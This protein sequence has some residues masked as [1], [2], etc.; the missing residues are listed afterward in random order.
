MH[1]RFFA[2]GLVLALSIA[3]AAL[4]HQSTSKIAAQ[5]ETVDAG[6]GGDSTLTASEGQRPKV[7]TPRRLLGLWLLAMTGTTVVLRARRPRTI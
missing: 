5:V 2:P 3:G 6:T 7:A 1:K 4:A